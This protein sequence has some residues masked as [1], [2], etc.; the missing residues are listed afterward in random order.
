MVGVDLGVNDVSIVGEP[1]AFGIGF[2]IL[3][4]VTL[5]GDWGGAPVTVAHEGGHIFFAALF[6]RK[7]R[8]FEMTSGYNAGTTVLDQRWGLGYILGVFVGYTTASLL[9]LAA[10][11]LVAAGNPWAV[12][13]GAL[14]LSLVAFVLSRNAL[15]LIVTFL[16]LATVV[17]TALFGEL[18]VQAAVAVG[19][20]WWLLIGN[21]RATFEMGWRGVN[22][23]ADRLARATLVPKVVWYVVWIGLSL[24]ALIVGAQLLLRPGYAIG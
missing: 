15:A 10:A 11:A 20:A 16:L 14:V 21:V 8:G 9:G 24:L 18:A 5:T 22:S 23:D 19:I 2:G 4:L 17:G 3:L 12:L 7:Q 1:V 13:W 6:N